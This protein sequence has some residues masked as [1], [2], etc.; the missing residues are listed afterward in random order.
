MNVLS[1]EWQSQSLSAL[2]E[3]NSV[4]GT[5]CV[6]GAHTGTILDLFARVWDGCERLMDGNDAQPFL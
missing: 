1:L 5:S 2:V 3:G 6:S 4:R